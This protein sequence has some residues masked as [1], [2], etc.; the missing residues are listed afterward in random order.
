MPP[1]SLEVRDL[2]H[3]YPGGVE[4]L[5][6][7]SLSIAPSESVAIVGQNGSGKT[8]LVKHF[9]GLLRPASGTVLIGG[10]DIADASVSDLAHRI[11]FVF[12]NPDDQLFNSRVDKEVGFGPRNLRLDAKQVDQLVVAALMMTGLAELR[13]TN[14]Y[15]LDVSVRK[16][17]ALAGVVAME[18]PVLVLDEPTMGQD[19]PGTARIGAIV[20]AWSA[21][22]RTVVAITHDMRF[23]AKHFGRIVVMRQGQ[24]IVDAPPSETFAAHNLQLL[25][26]T[27]L[28]APTLTG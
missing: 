15:D 11:G 16:L 8:T 5:R 12:Q 22:G 13:S 25:E 28:R 14:P 20:D 23:A 18:P 3:R 24:I 27:G 17:V 21:A 19:G 7:V 1:V 10:S 9:N 2:V 6:G 26:S 4:A